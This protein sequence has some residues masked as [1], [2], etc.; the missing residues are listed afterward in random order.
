[1]GGVVVQAIE[2]NLK[3]AGGFQ[4][5]AGQDRVPLVVEVVQ[6]AAEA[7]V[8]EFFWRDIRSFSKI[9]LNWRS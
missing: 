2:G 5:D 4:G 9:L 7:I 6:G 1:M 3:G 8:V